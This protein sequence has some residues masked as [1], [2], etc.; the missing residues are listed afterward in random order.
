MGRLRKKIRK[1]MK[2]YSMMFR[3]DRRG[4]TCCGAQFL[5]LPVYVKMDPTTPPTTTGRRTRRDLET[6]RDNLRLTSEQG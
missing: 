1:Q 6:R 4:R 5:A 3:T 2:L